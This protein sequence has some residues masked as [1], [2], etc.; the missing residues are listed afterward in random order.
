MFLTSFS[1]MKF[2]SAHVLIRTFMTGLLINSVHH[3]KSL[4][5]TLLLL[6][7]LH[8]G[9]PLMTACLICLSLLPILL[10]V[11]IPRFA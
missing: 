3:Y 10:I 1:E 9:L 5:E 11:S 8:L 2:T 7:G 4:F 6:G